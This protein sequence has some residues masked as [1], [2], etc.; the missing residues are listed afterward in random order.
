MGW[1]FLLGPSPSMPSTFMTPD[2]M[3]TRKPPRHPLLVTL[4]SS[5]SANTYE[6]P[7][8]R[9]KQFQRVN[10][11][12]SSGAD[13]CTPLIERSRRYRSADYFHFLLSFLSRFLP[14]SSSLF[15]FSLYLSL[16]TSLYH[17]SVL[18]LT[19]IVSLSF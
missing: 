18:S 1:H 12:K 15:L 16:S 7:G 17:S 4:P 19:D 6:L 2:Q 9:H 10:P 14:C 13:E 8:R 11:R 3:M 5:F